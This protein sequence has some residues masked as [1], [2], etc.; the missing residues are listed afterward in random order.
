VDSDNLYYVNFIG[1]NIV[2]SSGQLCNPDLHV[3]SLR[4]HD[5]P[6]GANTFMEFRLIY[7]GQLPA[8][9]NRPRLKDKQR[10]RRELHPQLRN[11]WNSHRS[12][13]ELSSARPIVGYQGTTEVT[14]SWAEVESERHKV[15]SEKGNHIHRFM[16]LITEE[17]YY[18]CALDILFLRRDMPGGI[19]EHNGDIDN[20]LKVLLDALRKPRQPQ[21]LEDEPQPPDFVPCFCLLSDDG[22]IDK[23]TVTT[24]QLLTDLTGTEAVNDVVL[25]IHVTVGFYQRSFHLAPM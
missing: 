23:I 4:F 19:F 24:D 20:R 15:V 21:E 8:E 5:P 12:L 14:A 16:P 25:I 11:L 9:K 10:I 6:E 18:G 17:T 3:E 13:R 7:R 2:D 1:D 22:L